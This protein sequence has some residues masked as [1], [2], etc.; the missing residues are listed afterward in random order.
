LELTSR[1]A[2]AQSFATVEEYESAITEA[3]AQAE[4]LD[5]RSE[6]LRAEAD[7]WYDRAYT[8]QMELEN[9]EESTYND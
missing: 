3:Y 8:L 9:F 2:Y 7:R 6:R 5:E 1:F 4:G